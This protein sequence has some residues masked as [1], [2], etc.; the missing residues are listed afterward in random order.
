MEA[1]TTNNDNI[2]ALHV[3]FESAR[4]SLDEN[5]TFSWGKE[6]GRIRWLFVVPLCVLG[7]NYAGRDRRRYGCHRGPIAGQYA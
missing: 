5:G 7:R 4:V 2:C 1:T 6:E 3:C